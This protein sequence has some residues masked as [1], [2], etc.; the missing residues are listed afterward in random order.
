PTS[1]HNSYPFLQ[2]HALIFLGY[3]GN[4]ESILKFVQ[5]CPVPALAPPIFWVSR[6]EAP[7]PF[8]EWLCDRDA[9]RV[10]HTDFDQLMHLIRNSL[11]I[12]LIDRKRWSQIGDRYYE[13]FENL[14]KEIEKLT[15][16]SEDTVAL[17]IASSAAEKTLPD[18]WNYVRR[19]EA[20][21]DSNPDGA[22][23]I[24][25]EGLQNFPDSRRLNF[26]YATFLEN[27]RK[28]MDGAEVHYKR[29][30]EADPKH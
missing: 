13:A 11:N 24:Y 16:G 5:N 26:G 1:A 10:D 15:A 28:D 23:K 6:R 25:Q 8:H 4:D 27:K 3:G 21:E 20:A 14:R 18:D 12:E 22:D 19:A 7:A 29:A 2:D 17:K 9:L 30:I